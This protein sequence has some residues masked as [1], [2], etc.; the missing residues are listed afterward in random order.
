MINVLI[1]DDE[2]FIRQGLL[3]LI[4]WNALG[5]QICGQASNG[6]QAL[7]CIRK[8]QPDL[9]ISD[10]KMPE[11]DGMQL[12]KII[13]EQYGGE[14]KMVLLS[15]FYEFE[16]A[17]QAIKY[18]VNDYILKPIVKDELLQVLEAFRAS[19]LERTEEKRHQEKQEQIVM[20]QHVQSILLGSADEETLAHVRTQYGDAAKFRCLM[21][22]TESGREQ[23]ADWCL[24]VEASMNQNHAGTVLKSFT[25]EKNRIL[26]IVTDLLLKQEAL[27]LEQYVTRLYAELSG[28]QSA[29]VA[30]YAGKEVSRLEELHESYYSCSR[31]KSLRFFSAYG[32]I[33]YYEHMDT[34]VFN[35]QPAGR[36]KQLFDGL[37]QA[38]EEQRIGDI[39]SHAQAIFQFF[40]EQRIEPG[41]VGIHLHYLAYTLL[42]LVNSDHAQRNPDEEWLQ[43]TFLQE[44]YA[45]LSME[46]NIENLCEF[47]YK[48]ADKLK[49]QQKWNAMGVLARVEAYIHEHYTENISL[50]LLGE[51]FYM[52]SAYLGQ[53]FKKHYGI[54]FSD[55]LNQIRIEEAARLLRRTDYRVY[56]IA[57]MVGYRD[58]DYFIN[59]FE[60]V[61][62]E[63]P[64]QYRKRAQAVYTS[65]SSSCSP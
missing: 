64:A 12:A 38:I 21:I 13:Y 22:E 46:E 28:I 62:G 26:H 9:V 60:K 32:P 39:H 10:I 25:G 1:V 34:T 49:E 6:V 52:N 45:M 20:V 31:I 36:E 16:Y 47:S 57:A 11:M 44:N 40:L 58:S 56:E 43:S 27:S 37:I 23:Q 17:K 15:G 3:L 2:P 54:S 18:Q 30:I 42:G 61:R 50:K 4:D 35:N 63:T 65:D 5:F 29:A 14:M 8:V 51:H 33:Y 7:E 24:H 41:I 19:F 48:C 53:I 55:Y 59:R